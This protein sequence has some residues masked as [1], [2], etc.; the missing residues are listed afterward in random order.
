MFA[1]SKISIH[2]N[3]SDCMLSINVTPL[4]TYLENLKFLVY[5][6]FGLGRFTMDHSLKKAASRPLFVRV[7]RLAP[8]TTAP[9]TALPLYYK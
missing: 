1:C 3:W 6:P 5:E 7:R 9:D 4:Y 2:S 8:E